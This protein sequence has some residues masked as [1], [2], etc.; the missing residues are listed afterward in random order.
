MC[1]SRPEG[2]LKKLSQFPKKKMLFKHKKFVW[3]EQ[4]MILATV[5]WKQRL[6]DNDQYPR[7]DYIPESSKMKNTSKSLHTI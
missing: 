7:S 6:L 2:Y 1:V 3:Y 4:V 5:T